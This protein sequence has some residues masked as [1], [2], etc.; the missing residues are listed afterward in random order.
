MGSTSSYKLPHGGKTIHLK[1]E[2]KVNLDAEAQSR[3]S[4]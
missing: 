4:R 2:L 3:Q 1:H